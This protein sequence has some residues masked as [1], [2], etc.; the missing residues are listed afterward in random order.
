[1]YEIEKKEK[2]HSHYQKRRFSARCFL[3]LRPEVCQ[4]RIWRDIRNRRVRERAS[5]ECES[6]HE[7]ERNLKRR[8]IERMKKTMMRKRRKRRKRRRRKEWK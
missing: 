8:M 2:Q 5:V 6:P 4:S 3:S 1:M 7:H